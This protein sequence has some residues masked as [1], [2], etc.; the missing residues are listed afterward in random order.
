MRITIATGPTLPVPPVIGGAIPKMWHGLAG[1]FARRGHEVCICAR[2]YPGQPDEEFR[3]GVRYLR[4]GGFPQGRSVW[5][6]LARDFAYVMANGWGLPQADILVTNDFW[7]PV[8]AGWLRPAAGRIVIN[9]NRFPKGQFG[10]YRRAACIAAASRAVRDEILREQPALAERTCVIPNPVDTNLLQPAPAPRASGATRTLL[11]VGRVH[12]EKG[13]HVLARAFAQVA[14]RRAGW[15]LRIVG[16]W[17]E[18]Q[19]GGGEAYLRQLQD[20]LR[21]APAELAG[22]VF[23]PARL[24]GE[25]RAAD[26]FCYPSLADR[27][28]SFGLAALE[29]MA[30]GVPAV[31]SGLACFRDFVAD[32]DNG[33]MFDHH[34]ADPAGALAARLEA[35]M[36]DP[37]GRERAG[38]R[39]AV[40]ARGFGMC[41]VADQYLAIFSRTVQG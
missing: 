13:V 10:L 38:A 41:E 19:G 33:W 37:A 8:F 34:A 17:E 25:Y 11:F 1:E 7:L 9:A 6:D 39:A 28:E 40:T 18:P 3:D 5:L 32:G 35:A 2:R 23:D 31:V 22:A 29:A 36:G 24:A 12:P 21:G 30:C 14:P 16:P 20:L 27:G 26:L 15:R 4:A